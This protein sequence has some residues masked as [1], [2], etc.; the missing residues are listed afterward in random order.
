M[1]SVFPLRIRHLR[2]E[3]KLTQQQVS[4]A[5]G[6]SRSTYAKYETGENQPDHAMLNK[7]ANFFEVTVDYLL[8]RDDDPKGTVVDSDPISP[9]EREFLEW[10]KKHVT[11][12]FFYDW[13]KAEDKDSWLRGLRLIYE[14]EKGRKPVKRRRD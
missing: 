12:T 3:R 9:E 14:M 4:Q 5:L 10:V 7:I 11:G 2:R 8:G 1:G 13:Q 6:I